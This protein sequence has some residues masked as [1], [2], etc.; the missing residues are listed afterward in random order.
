MNSKD[1]QKE[2]K[3]ETKRTGSHAKTRKKYYFLNK[4]IPGSTEDFC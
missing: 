2:L 4:L 1:Y 3:T